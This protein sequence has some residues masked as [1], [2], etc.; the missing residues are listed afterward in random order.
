MYSTTARDLLAAWERGLS[1][2]SAHRLVTLLTAVYPEHSEEYLLKLPLGRRDALALDAHKRLF[3]AQL[4]SL[5]ACPVCHEQLELNLNVA[6]I[7][8]NQSQTP[9]LACEVDGFR[10]EFRL[11]DSLDVML[12]QTAAS[13]QTAHQL[14]LGRCL[15]SAS[16]TQ[17][18]YQADELPEHV[19]TT[20]EAAMSEAD[21]QANIQLDLSCP[22]CRHAWLAAF[23]VAAF[24]WKEVHAWAQAML[25][26][27]HLL[28]KAYA[29]REA[30]ILAMS[31][32]RRRLY[33]EQVAG[34]RSS[35][36]LGE[37]LDERLEEYRAR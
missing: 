1:Q 36:R 22:A 21:P 16:K 6:D 28:A 3:G 4:V 32:T 25:A 26:E 37:R 15:L 30:D 18:H 35:G 5:A 17:R 19:L 20:M 14:L 23:D 27:V 2:T 13:V 29:W 7:Q 8:V 33:I 12:A 31:P 10:L 11:P 24:M 34:E 9:E